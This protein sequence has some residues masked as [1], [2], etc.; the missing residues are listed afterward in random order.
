MTRAKIHNSR[1]IILFRS[2]LNYERWI[3]NSYVFAQTSPWK[4]S[5]DD[6]LVKLQPARIICKVVKIDKSE[7]HWL[8]ENSCKFL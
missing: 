1:Y 3:G 4:M 6:L 5:R 2:E 7:I 8:Q